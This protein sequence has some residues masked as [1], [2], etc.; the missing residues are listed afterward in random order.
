MVIHAL[1]NNEARLRGENIGESGKV[2]FEQSC[3]DRVSIMNRSWEWDKAWSVEKIP[4]N[5]FP[6]AK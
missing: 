1:E 6:G 4:R 5:Q 3:L 2:T